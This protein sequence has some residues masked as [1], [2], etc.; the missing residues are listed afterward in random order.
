MPCISKT[1][2]RCENASKKTKNDRTVG[3]VGIKLEFNFS[4][5]SCFT[6]L[7]TDPRAAGWQGVVHQPVHAVRGRGRQRPVTS[8]Q[9]DQSS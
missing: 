1:S 7:Q 8:W 3:E 5:L 6:H 4:N 9:L 2:L